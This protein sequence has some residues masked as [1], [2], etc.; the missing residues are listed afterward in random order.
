MA[1][2]PATP[3]A[4]GTVKLPGLGPVSK[5]TLAIAAV[6]GGGVLAYVYIRK[7]HAASGIGTGGTGAIDPATGFPY[8]SAEDTAALDANAGSAGLGFGSGVG[9]GAG[10]G[11]GQ[12]FD[13][14]ASQ[15]AVTT[16]AEWEQGAIADLEAGGVDQATISAAESGLPRYLAHL[17][18]SSAQAAAVQ[19]AVGLAGPP[20]SGGPFSIRLAP[21]PPRKPAAPEVTVPAVTGR[22]Y[23]AAAAELTAHGLHARRAEPD[24][25]LVIMQNP[26]AGRKVRKGSEVVLSGRTAR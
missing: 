23:M 15:P 21:E 11:T 14:N 18:L 6:V 26:A 3:A 1:D 22:Q 20:P 10:A 8:G 5:K 24:V 9:L 13:P 25:G 2:A 12:F 16:N 4:K 19:M 7:A 17:T